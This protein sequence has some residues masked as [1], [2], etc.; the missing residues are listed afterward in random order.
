MKNL[1]E[2][3]L[4]DGYYVLENKINRNNQPPSTSTSTTQQQQQSEQ[5]CTKL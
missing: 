4:V 5:F 2:N 3:L 1:F